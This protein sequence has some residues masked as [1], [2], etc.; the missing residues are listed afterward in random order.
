VRTV[1]PARVRRGVGAA[2]VALAV[3]GGAGA[4]ATTV[5]GSATAAPGAKAGAGAPSS[6]SQPPS[7]DK[8]LSQAAQQSCAELPKDAVT[9]AFGATG[10]TVTSAGGQT[11]PGGIQQIKC[12]IDG[13]GGFRVNVVVQVWPPKLITTADQF[14]SAL[15]QQFSDVRTMP[16]PDADI[17]GTFQETEQGTL[18]DEGFAAKKDPG[19][20]SVEVLLAGIADSPG[21]QPKLIQ[22]V[23]ALAKAP[24]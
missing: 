2:A 8:A 9:T 23:A 3:A 11:L 15:R 20:T 12:V 14:V 7:S 10:V 16:I 24:S 18:V 17:G 19:S 22:F 6:G 5:T 4:C 21:I 13:K 1:R